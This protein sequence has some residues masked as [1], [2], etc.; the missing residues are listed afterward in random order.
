NINIPFNF[1]PKNTLE[2]TASAGMV[3]DTLR[4]I[5]S[6]GS[7]NYG[8]TRSFTVGGGVEYLSSVTSGPVMPY[9]NASLRITNNLL[10]SG[11]Y[12][13][14]VRSKGTLTY[15]LPSNIQL[16]LN[17][18]R[19]DKD[20]TAISYNYLEERRASLSLP[21]RAKKLSAYSRMSVYQIVLPTLNYTTGEW[22]LSGP[23]LGIN[24]NFTT[25]ALFIGKDEPY[26]YSNISM[27]LR[28]P[29]GFVLM[30]QAQYGYTRN[31]LL[32]A[33]LGVEKHL[34]VHGFMNLSLERNF[35]SNLTIGEIGFR[36]DFSFAQIGLSVRQANDRTTLV[37]YARG[38]LIND[39]RT[40]YLH[41]D[42]RNNVGKGGITIIPFID[43]NANGKRDYDEQKLPGLNLHTS[44][45]RIEKNES[46][47]T[48]RILGLEPYTRC[49]IEFDESSFE[50]IAWRLKKRTYSV[51]VD[52]NQLKLLEVPVMVLGEA[53][54]MV[55]LEKDGETRGLG[56][57]IVQFFKDNLTPVSRTL[58][59]EDGF[60]SYLGLAPGSYIARVDTAQ[61]RK[62]QMTSRPDS[63]TFT[64]RADIDGDIVDGLD[65]TLRKIVSIDTTKLIAP[66][67]KIVKG[68][69]SYLIIHEEVRELVTITEDYWAMQLGAFKNK[70]YAEAWMKRIS[71]VVD[72]DV[73][74]INEDGFYKVRVTGFKDREELDSYIPALQNAGFTEIWIIHNK[75]KIVER[76][77]TRQDSIARITETAVERPLPVIVPGTVVQV[78]AFRT[79]EEASAIIDRLLAAVENLITVR[80]EDGVYKVQLADI[81]DTAEIQKLIPI[82]EE[83][84]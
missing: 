34:F 41:A 61:M 52:P 73:E 39:S 29:L 7:V 65:F 6:R 20:Q 24:T 35:R 1:L 17:Y 57:I 19:Y 70:A 56:R 4:S 21:I 33:K 48:I 63:L 11:E 83:K 43:I 45:G 81:Q 3:E 46:D 72:K 54:G 36:Y 66:P 44:M 15:R 42:N 79:Q 9:L 55:N 13:Y 8:L 60:F 82:L 16:D 32:S 75:A 69:T 26:V 51:T 74:L 76:I 49:L 80:I 2:Y 23:L 58:S 67:E 28:M 27:S 30:P 53:S 64:I 22:L 77:V 71:A 68:D 25:Y 84:G 38:S 10:V 31:Q 40:K 37:Q 50:N 12:T 5:F 62:L 18:T 14:G 47:T 59:E 78:A